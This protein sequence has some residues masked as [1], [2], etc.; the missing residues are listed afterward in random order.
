MKKLKITLRVYI[1][2]VGSVFKIKK[3]TLPLRTGNLGNIA[4]DNF[5]LVVSD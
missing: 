4:V 5:I 2:Q 3:D 1:S